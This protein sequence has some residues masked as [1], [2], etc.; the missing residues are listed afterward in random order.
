MLAMPSTELE[1]LEEEERLVSIRR[2]RLHDRIDY[3]RANGN[4]DGTPASPEQIASLLEQERELSKT[5]KD[6]QAR[7]VGAD[8]VTVGAGAGLFEARKDLQLSPAGE[9]PQPVERLGVGRF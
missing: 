8:R 5:R 7:I 1:S 9:T 4:A 2:E 3:V 6:L